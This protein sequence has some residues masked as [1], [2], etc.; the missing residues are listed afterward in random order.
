M[1][2]VCAYDR[3][4]DRDESREEQHDAGTSNTAFGTQHTTEHAHDTSHRTAHHIP[5]DIPV[6][7]TPLVLVDVHTCPA[8]HMFVGG[9]VGIVLITSCI[10]MSCHVV[11]CQ[12][13]ASQL[14]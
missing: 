3:C 5:Y 1:P 9:V 2:I 7:S 10:R 13:D 8:V 11:S 4:D 6:V 14:M 12:C